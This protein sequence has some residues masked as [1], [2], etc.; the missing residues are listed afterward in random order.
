ME[1]K[2]I[3]ENTEIIGAMNIIETENR[4]RERT[5]SGNYGNNR[6]RSS[7]NSRLRSGSQASTNRDRIRCYNCREYDHLGGI[8]LTL[9]KKDTKSNYKRC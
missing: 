7:R 1:D 2:T 6:D 5:F 9:E 3:E 8:V 4:S